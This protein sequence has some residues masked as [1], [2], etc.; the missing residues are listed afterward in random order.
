MN[1][2]IE[3]ILCR[4]SVRAG[5]SAASV[6]GQILEDV[7]RCGLAAPSSKNA[8]PWRFHVVTNR[9]VLDQL[10]RAVENSEDIESYV[11]FDPATGKPRP[12]W[13][14]T[15]TESAAVLRAAPVAIFVENT[16]S[17]SRGR[18][19]LLEAT[20]EALAG[21]IVGYTFEVMGIGAAIENMWLAAVAH[22]LSGVFMG[23]ILIAERE[24]QE[25]LSIVSDLVGVLALG[26]A[27]TPKPHTVP[28]RGDGD[29]EGVRWILAD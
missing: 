18:Q 20:P 6:P 5:F 28:S 13:S 19:V 29:L 14:S 23:D 17:F 7:V 16:G 2:V 3:T 10:A 27:E 9:L 21:S 22:G 25:R 1:P 12:E 26:Y 8:R 4:H 15:V 24:I 11:P